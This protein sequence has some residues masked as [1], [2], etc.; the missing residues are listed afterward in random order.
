MDDSVVI[1]DEIIYAEEKNFNEKNLNCKTRNFCILLT[2]LLITIILLITVSIYSFL[3]KFRT[4]N[5]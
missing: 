2:F 1:C 4:K 5:L 3:I